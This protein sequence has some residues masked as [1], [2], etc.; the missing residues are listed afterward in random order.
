MRMDGRA[1]PLMDR[2]EV[3]VVLLGMVA[4]ATSTK[5]DGCIY[6]NVVVVALAA[7][8]VVALVGAFGI[9]MFL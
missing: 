1:Y 3:G 6:R 5:T 7:V 9:Y 2:Q 8:I 4:V